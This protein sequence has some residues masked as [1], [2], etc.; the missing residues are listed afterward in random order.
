[1]RRRTALA[2]AH[3]FRLHSPPVH[4]E[5]GPQHM[6]RD[7]DGIMWYR[8]DAE[9]AL[10]AGANVGTDTVSNKK[11]LGRREGSP[12]EGRSLDQPQGTQAQGCA[13]RVTAT[14]IHSDRQPLY[15]SLVVTVGQPADITGGRQVLVPR[16]PGVDDVLSVVD[17]TVTGSVLVDGDAVDHVQGHIIATRVL[18]LVRSQKDIFP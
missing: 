13:L 11:T 8:A 14:R 6:A 3:G 16:T 15:A 12:Y 18:D 5:C 17:R 1:M 4:V 10:T 7:H 9:G 2:P